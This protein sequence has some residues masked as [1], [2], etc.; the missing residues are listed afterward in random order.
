MIKQLYDLQLN[1][2]FV[3]LA[4]QHGIIVYG[5]GGMGTTIVPQ[6]L[7]LQY[8]RGGWGGG[9]MIPKFPII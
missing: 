9:T 8:I 7:G 4:K 1:N 2:E 6:L 5:A 3:A